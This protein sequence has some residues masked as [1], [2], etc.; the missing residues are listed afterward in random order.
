MTVNRALII[1]PEPTE[2]DRLLGLVVEVWPETRASAAGSLAAA[3]GNLAHC[4][5][6]LLITDIYLPDGCGFELLETVGRDY[7]DSPRLVVTRHDDPPHILATLQ[8]DVDGYLIKGQA[9][10]KTRD[11]LTALARGEP[12]LSPQV[13]RAVLRHFSQNNGQNSISEIDPDAQAEDLGLTP[14]E[15]EVLRLLAH[16][17]DRHQVGEALAIK[18]ST[19]AG[20]I[21]SLYLKLDVST[22]A[23]MTIAAVKLGLVHLE[24]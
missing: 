6:G 11:L 14:R 4:M 24:D 3:Y 10:Q 23:E 5:P 1:D 2:R 15:I 17:A 22:R 9:S 12:A 21:K 8:R 18:P 20:Y 13:T 16:G 7:P 19:V